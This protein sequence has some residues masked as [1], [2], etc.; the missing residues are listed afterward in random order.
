MNRV[1]IEKVCK[2]SL[3]VLFLFV[4]NFSGLNKKRKRGLSPNSPLFLKNNKSN[5]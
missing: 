3:W 1:C 5:C 2:N 4:F